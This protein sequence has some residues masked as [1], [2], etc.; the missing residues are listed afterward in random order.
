M[1]LIQ[2]VALVQ[3]GGALL[4]GFTVLLFILFE[5]I[6]IGPL[7]LIAHFTILVF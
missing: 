6:L 1:A 2:G 4:R 5:S 3:G 7:D